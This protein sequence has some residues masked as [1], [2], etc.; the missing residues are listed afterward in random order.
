MR[1]VRPFRPADRRLVRAAL[2]LAAA[3]LAGC[4]TI[5][6]GSTTSE[7]DELFVA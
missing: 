1:C 3:A 5:G 6:S 4:Q 2:L 7:A